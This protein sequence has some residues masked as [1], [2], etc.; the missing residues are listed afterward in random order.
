MFYSVQQVSDHP[1]FVM[2]DLIYS[3][4]YNATQGQPFGKNIFQ[5]RFT[6]TKTLWGYLSSFRGELESLYNDLLSLEEIERR[7]IYSQLSNNNMIELLCED[8]SID[9]EI[10]LNFEIGIGKKIKD[11][12]S[13]C[14]KKLDLSH[15]RRSDCKIK[16]THRYYR[17]YIKLN[18]TV[19]PFCSINSYKNPQNP[20]REDFDHYLCKSKYPLAAANMHNLIPMCNECN[21]DNKKSKDILYDSGARI[22][23]FYPFSKFS[24]V[25][26][27]IDC[28]IEKR[29]PFGKEWTVTLIVKDATEQN[30]VD[31]WE[32]IF[33]IKSRLVN[34]IIQYNDE[35]MNQALDEKISSKFLSVDSYRDFMKDR[36]NKELRK[37]SRRSEPK[38]LLK[39]AFYDFADKKSDNAYLES[40]IRM[41]NESIDALTE[42]P[43]RD[44]YDNN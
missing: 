20:R 40:Y 44:Q 30:K 7:H 41:H 35:W 29:Y 12:L 24:C 39:A 33:S 13:V 19:C 23:S 11:L 10:Y 9:P 18:K 8:T 43:N 32:K 36:K 17:D 6:R 3:V 38:A 22:Q 26:I 14:Y 28:S 4:F 2:Q 37:F 31:N 34:E 5:E 16:P 27:E 25:G 42:W 1:C 15:F 21:Q